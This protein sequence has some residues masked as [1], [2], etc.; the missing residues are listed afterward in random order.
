MTTF[1]SFSVFPDNMRLPQVLQIAGMT[2]ISHAP[3]PIINRGDSALGY[4]FPDNGATIILP[5]EV[6][7]LR[8]R[9]CSF[10]GDATVEALGAAGSISKHQVPHNQCEDIFLKGDRISAVLLTGGGNEGLIERI[11]FCTG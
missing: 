5:V 8:I 2:L 9:V 11:E 4:Q 10:A 3:D 1:V 7:E 6:K